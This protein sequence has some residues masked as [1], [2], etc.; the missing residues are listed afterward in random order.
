[1]NRQ[2]PERTYRSV[3]K[4]YTAT[5]E[6]GSP[7]YRVRDLAKRFHINASTVARIA[8]A[9]GLDRN[10]DGVRYGTPVRHRKGRRKG[11]SIVTHKERVNHGQSGEG[12][13][14]ETTAHVSYTFGW[15][16]CWLSGYA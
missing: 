12:E 15:T 6:D 3:A 5:N 13:T 11:T 1:M 2:I 10:K 4:A 14:R 8:H 16:H 7:R 9:A